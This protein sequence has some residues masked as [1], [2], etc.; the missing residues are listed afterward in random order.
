MTSPASALATIQTAL[1]G[2]TGL[3]PQVKAG[4]INT[5]CAIVEIAG[6][7][8]PSMFGGS[9]DYQIRVL[10]LV[11]VGDFRNSLERIWDYINPDGSASTSVATALLSVQSLGPV[12]FDGPGV[13]EWAGVQYAGGIFTASLLG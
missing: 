4:K 9:V 3:R 7:T 5:P 10:L 2:V 13:V 12:T 6:L 1:D 11:Q 8:T